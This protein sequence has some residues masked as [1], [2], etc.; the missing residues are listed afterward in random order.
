MVYTVWEYELYEVSDIVGIFDDGGYANPFS[1]IALSQEHIT[2]GIEINPPTKIEN[3]KGDDVNFI[4][5][6]GNL[7]FSTE[8][9]FVEI[10]SINGTLVSQKEVNA[11]TMSINLNNGIYI[12][13]AID[14]NNNIISVNKLVV[15]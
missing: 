7:T 15:R 8:V 2:K 5:N 11:T 14:Y 10:Y 6:S 9:D 13:R 4:Y 1:F 3:T 12:V